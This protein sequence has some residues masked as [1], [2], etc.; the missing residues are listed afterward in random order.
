M[1][2]C[3]IDD[4]G[5]TI[6]QGDHAGASRRDAPLG[7]GGHRACAHGPGRAVIL[8]DPF[9]G[10]THLPDITLVQPVFLEG[11]PAPVF[12][13]RQAHHSDVGGIDPGS[14]PLAQEIFQEGL[15]IPPTKLVR[16]GEICEDVMALIL[17]NVAHPPRACPGSLQRTQITSNRRQRKSGC[18]RSSRAMGSSASAFTPVPC[19]TIPS[20]SSASS[21]SIP[22]GE[23]SY[24]DVMDG[25]GFSRHNIA[26][27]VTVRITGDPAPVDFTGT[28]LTENSGWCQRQLRD[29]SPPHSIASAAWCGGRLYQ[30]GH[31]ASDPARHCSIRHHR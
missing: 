24:E 13:V 5:Q 15:I 25:D 8:N 30:T 3:P 20:A 26:I 23:Y 28:E 22:D 21:A 19:R 11:S 17:A 29:R 10:G 7:E 14:M 6:A 27:N 2:S 12:Y 18:A 1:F 31:L 16:R 9:R 4:R